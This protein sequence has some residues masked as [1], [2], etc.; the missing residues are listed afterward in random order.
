MN[1][2]N[3]G[4]ITF[5]IAANGNIPLSNL[6]DIVYSLSNN[7]YL[8]TGNDGYQFFRFDKRLKVFCVEHKSGLSPLSRIC[9]YIHT[10]L[11][12]SYNIFKLRNDVD[13][14][15]F[16]I[17]GDALLLPM[18]TAKI[19]R[20]HCIL[21]LASSATQILKSSKDKFY[22]VTEFLSFVNFTLSDK[23][24]LHS[25]NLLY[26]WD[27]ERF[28]KKVF[29]AHEYFLDFDHFNLK[30]DLR[31]RRNLVGY[32]GTLTEAKG[33]LN[34]ILAIPKVIEKRNDLKF[35]IAGKGNLLDSI[36]YH[37]C[38]DNLNDIVEYLGWIP[39][40]KLPDYLNEIKLLVIPSY[41]ESGPIIALEAMACGTPIL[42][43]KVGQISNMINDGE[44]GFILEN[45]S[46][47]CI[48]ANIMRVLSSSN[49]DQVIIN[50]Q[51]LVRQNFTY[52]SA[53]EK[54]KI[55]L[56]SI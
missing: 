27:M 36:L 4:I 48:A 46:P 26:E 40:N 55:I 30:K 11:K 53:V 9:K 17:G 29:I 45:N 32:I 52:E 20:K 38:K 2:S 7:L 41:T 13:V 31:D 51:D 8:I 10:N 28:Q 16:F 23:I 1:N 25:E 15:I 24:V 22:K 37:L 19:L 12:I 50:A 34:Y 54:Y 56:E 47:E 35:L 18:L 14:W 44:N 33:V 3:I 42:I 6:I 43:T 5:P 49:L 39:H 21:S